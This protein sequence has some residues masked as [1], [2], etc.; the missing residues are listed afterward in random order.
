MPSDEVG[1]DGAA[2]QHAAAD[3]EDLR[4]IGQPALAGVDTGE[5][6]DGGLDDDGAPAA[7]GGDVLLGGRVLPHLGVHRGREDDRTAGGEQG[8]GEQ[9]V[10][11][12]VGRLGEHVGGRGGDDDE[13]GVLSDP[14]VRDL[15]DVVPDLGGDR[16]ARERRPGGGADE[17]ERRLG[18]DDPYVMSGLGQPAQ[19]LA[20]LVRGDAAADPQNDL[21]L[22]HCVSP[23]SDTYALRTSTML[24]HGRGRGSVAPGH[25]T[26]PAVTTAGPVVKVRFLLTARGPRWPR[27]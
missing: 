3:L 8:V 5:T 22:V 1:G 20:R 11:Q 13:V 16:M 14:H 25:T 12:A 18:R 27:R 23:H 10:G 7:Q 19:Q 24:P 9:V 2:G 15:V 17:V 4:R 26:G 6:P 21:R